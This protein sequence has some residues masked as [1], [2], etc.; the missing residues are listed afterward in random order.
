MLSPPKLKLLSGQLDGVE[1]TLSPGDNVFHVGPARSL[2]EGQL[3]T[4]LANADNVFYIP[5]DLAPGSFRVRVQDALVSLDVRVGDAGEWAA[6]PLPLNEVIHV[7]GL[8]LAV[9]EGDAAWSAAVLDHRLPVRVDAEATPSLALRHARGAG[10]ARWGALAV[11]MV[12]VAAGGWWAYDR[13]RPATQVRTLEAALAH[14]PYDYSVVHDDKGHL[15]AFADSAEALA[16]G[17][18]ASQRAGRVLDH[19]LNRQQEADRIGAVLDSASVPYAVIRLRTPQRPEVIIT[20]LG[21]DDAE[22]R[23]HVQALLAPQMPYAASIDVRSMGDAQ[24]V[25]LARSE[26]RARGISTRAGLQAGRASVA[27][28]IFL[29]DASLHAMARYRDDFVQQWGE[30]RVR[31]SIRLWDDLLKGRSYQYSHDQL[32]SVGEGRWDFSTAGSR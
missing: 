14:S 8:A 15:Y 31:I 10:V 7:A 6:Q 1:F 2:G 17:Q 5:G 29:D 30:R 18:R 16:W 12:A 22:R 26:L 13:Q 9:R 11:V 20:A 23:R 21:A 32:L 27:N 24:L 3:G 25:A 28:D 4:T 19:Y